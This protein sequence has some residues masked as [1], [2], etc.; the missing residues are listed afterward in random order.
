M[1]SDGEH[2]IEAA[3]KARVVIR[4]GNVV[5]VERG[6]L[7]ACPLAAR[8]ATPVTSFSEDEIR[9]N[10]EG[11]ISSFGMCTRKREVLSDDD[12]VLF[13]ASELLSAAVRGGILDC[14]VLACDGA[15]TV[16]TPV[17][18]MIQG[19]GGKM[20]GL[21][22]TTP[23]EEVIERIEAH[24]GYAV[25]P[26]NGAIDMH[27]GVRQAYARGYRHVAVTTASAQEAKCLRDAFPGVLITAVHTTGVTD[28]DAKLLADNCD[29]I[30]PCA[31]SGLR[32]IAG[33]RALAQGGTSVP[34]YAMTSQGKAVILEKIRQSGQQVVIKGAPLPFEG[35]NGPS[36]L[37]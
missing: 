14:A 11:R 13:G 3:G 34:V 23:L 27:A 33:P 36:P 7:C 24:G 4:E 35:G 32:R 28:V 31:S 8:F 18:R 17:S 6:V 29:L 30:F 19:I 16:I 12:F 22:A 37:V 9:A 15:G 20:S 21:V 10:I 1:A 25:T 26:E 5:S 2:I